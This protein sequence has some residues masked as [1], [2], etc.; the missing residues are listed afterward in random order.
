MSKDFWSRRR[1]AVEAEQRKDEKAKENAFLAERHAALEETTD[2]E[3]LA[4]LDLP[5]PD[6]LTEGDDF[7]VF[8]AKAVPDRIRRRALRT[9]W[10]SNPV[11]AN[12]DHLVE[13]GEDY[14]DGATVVENLQTAYQVGK[15]M[16]EHVE[17]M[18]Q[19]AAEAEDQ[20]VGEGPVEDEE[21]EEVDRDA[22][23]ANAAPAEPV[24]STEALID[25]DSQ[26]VAV[27]RRMKFRVEEIA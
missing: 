25:D 1:A 20:P 4:Q 14:T 9:L 11:L 12:V 5:D 7:T 15:G 10:K 24:T 2:E 22:L 6:D 8:M 18:A 27:P 13:Y 17:E 26:V 3:I 16:M 19:Q 21:T 23:L